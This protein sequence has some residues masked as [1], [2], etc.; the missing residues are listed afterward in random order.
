MKYIND[1]SGKALLYAVPLF[2]TPFADKVG[3]ILFQDQWPSW[4]MIWGCVLLGLIQMCIGL[5]AFYDGSYERKKSGA[6]SGNTQFLTRT[7]TESIKT[8]EAKP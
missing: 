7:N 6:D 8:N 5:R 1:I 4:P 2:L 3:S